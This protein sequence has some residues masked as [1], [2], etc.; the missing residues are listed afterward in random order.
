MKL[1]LA[2]AVL[3]LALATQ[4][5]AQTVEGPTDAIV[6][7][8]NQFGDTVSELGQDI[9]LKTKTAFQRIHE[10]EFA[11]SSRNWFSDQLEKMK[12]KLEELRQ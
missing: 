12:A 5:E 11:T 10:S 3:L 4:S 8:F 2:V 6:D 1:Y 9:A 7:K